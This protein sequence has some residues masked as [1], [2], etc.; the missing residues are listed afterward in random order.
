ME[1]PCIATFGPHV[2]AKLYN[3]LVDKALGLNPQLFNGSEPL[4]LSDHRRLPDDSRT[5]NLSPS[6]LTFL[7]ESELYSTRSLDAC[8]VPYVQPLDP[9]SFWL[10]KS[11]RKPEQN[12]SAISLFAVAP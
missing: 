1:D 7:S 4:P 11:W 9:K 5:H 10:Y 6:L 12:P 8:L 3:V 2:C